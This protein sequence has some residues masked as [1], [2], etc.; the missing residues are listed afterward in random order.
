MTRYTF[1]ICATIFSRSEGSGR[2]AN[3]AFR[4]SGV[5]C[6]SRRAPEDDMI[7]TRLRVRSGEFAAMSVREPVG[8]IELAS[9]GRQC[10]KTARLT[11][12]FEYTH[13][14]EPDQEACYRAL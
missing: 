4:A 9:V 1:I 12:W 7:N 3:S 2:L 13:P 8:V 10:P 5:D 6:G 14:M 11:R